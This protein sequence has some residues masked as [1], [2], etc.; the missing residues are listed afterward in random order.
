[1]KTGCIR[2]PVDARFLK[3]YAWQLEFCDGNQCAAAL[4]SFFEYCHNWKLGQREQAR[5]Q[6]NASEAVGRGRTQHETLLQWHTAKEL[7]EAVLIFKRDT[8]DKVL[9]PKGAVEVMKNP[10]PRQ[11]HDHTKYFL[12]KPEAVNDWIDKRFPENRQSINEKSE[13]P[14]ET[15]SIPG[16]V[17]KSA[18]G[19]EKS[20]ISFEKSTTSIKEDR[21]RKRRRPHAH[22]RRT[23]LL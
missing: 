12:F 2:H 9:V 14:G 3:I 22:A 8:I 4:L 6:N 16:V 21:Q 20:E 1:V 11:W 23:L 10:D 15:V 19:I 17:E 13:I 7:E 5:S 18:I